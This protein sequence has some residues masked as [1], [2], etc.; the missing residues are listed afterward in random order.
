MVVSFKDAELEKTLSERAAGNADLSAGL[1]AK[2]DLDRYYWMMHQQGSRFATKGEE[3]ELICEALKET[4]FSEP[5]IIQGVPGTVEDQI[6]VKH[7]AKK[8]MTVDCD[9]LVD[10]LHQASALQLLTLVDRVERHWNSIERYWKDQITP[11]GDNKKMLQNSAQTQPAETKR[12]KVD[13][14]KI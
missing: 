4:T 5:W 1:V 12:A 10:R 3:L 9:Q 11:T 2:R 8:H 7:L 14:D 6:S 13:W